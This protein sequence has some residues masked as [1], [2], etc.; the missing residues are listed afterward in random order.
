MTT[1]CEQKKKIVAEYQRHEG[2]TGSPEIQIALL[3]D[4][5]TYMTEHMR[6]HKK[7]FASRRGLL[8]MV[9]QRNNLLRYLANIDVSRYQSTIQR[10]GLRK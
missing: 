2:D 4:R 8:K 1:T 3:T 7:D 5:I 10:L 6:A 9:A